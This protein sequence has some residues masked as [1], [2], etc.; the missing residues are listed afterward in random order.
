MS[1]IDKRDGRLTF[2]NSAAFRPN[3]G[4]RTQAISVADLYCDIE[5]KPAA[6][7]RDLKSGLVVTALATLAAAFISDHY[8]VPLTLMAFLVGLSLNFLAEDVKLAPGLSF[9]AGTVLKIGIVLL[10]A[11][12]TTGQ[13]GNLGPSVLLAVTLVAALTITG[14]IV[15]ARACRF[16]VGFGILAAGAVAICGASA[17]LAIFAVLTERRTKRAELSI[18]LIGIAALSAIAMST[19]PIIAREAGMTDRE[20]GFFLGAAIHDVAQALG[21]G[22]TFSHQAGGIATIIK[23]TRVCLLAPLLAIISMSF[24]VRSKRREGVFG[25]PWFVMGFLAVVVINSTGIVPGEVALRLAELGSIFVVIA[26]TAAGIRS[27]MAQLAGYGVRPLIV[28]AGATAWCATLSFLC[29]KLL[30]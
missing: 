27:P 4:H 18:V 3:A 15:I 11:R 12:V 26:L 7:W 21:A 29:A 14:G 9:A 28:I 6:R 23:L 13:I 10:G 5:G 30:L 20:A 17:A 2:E 22:Y 16:D 19:Y 8:G 25:L 24:G 1:D